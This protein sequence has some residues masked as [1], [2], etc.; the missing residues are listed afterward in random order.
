[1]ILNLYIDLAHDTLLNKVS[2]IK[3]F[4]KS[5]EIKCPS[6]QVYVPLNLNV[7]VKCLRKHITFAYNIFHGLND[8][9]RFLFHLSQYN[10]F[11]GL[12]DLTR[13]LIHLCQVHNSLR[14]QTYSL[15]KACSLRFHSF[16]QNSRVHIIYMKCFH[17]CFL[18]KYYSIILY[19][20]FRVL[21]L[22]MR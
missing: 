13:F 9:Q 20:D 22:L 15:A 6:Y 4:D 14:V 8:S 12:N 5:L 3:T 16:T 2:C 7:K 11:H 17:Q 1:M 19:H 18:F 21:L 10:I